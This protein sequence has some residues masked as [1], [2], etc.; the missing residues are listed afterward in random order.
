MDK[1]KK[2]RKERI[3]LIDDLI[4]DLQ[5][6][7]ENDEPVI[8]MIGMTNAV[9]S[10]NKAHL[11]ASLTGFMNGMICKNQFEKEDLEKAVKLASIPDKKFEGI[12]NAIK[13]LLAE[14]K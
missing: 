1:E 12:I 6:A 9:S 8:V 14:V 10:N 7:K 4:K 11:L 2:W 5:D 3:K 13:D